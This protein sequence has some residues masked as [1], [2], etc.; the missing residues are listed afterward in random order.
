MTRISGRTPG[1][2]RR[3]ANVGLEDLVAK[4]IQVAAKVDANP[5]LKICSLVAG[6][7][8]SLHPARPSPRRDHPHRTHL[9]RRPTRP[10]RTRP[11]HLAS[12]RALALARRLARRLP[13]HPPRTPDADH[14][15]ERARPQ[16]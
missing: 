7:I 8:A 14:L 10:Q 16:T 5:D 3:A 4:Q 13:G 11:H 15:P 2:C 9:R 6:M 12:A 1:W